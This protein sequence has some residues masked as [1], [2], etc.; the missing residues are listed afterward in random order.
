M[1]DSKNNLLNNFIGLDTP[2][3]LAD[4]SSQKRIH[5][6]GAA[7]PLVMKTAIEARDAL[8]PHYSNSHS[9]AHASAHI[10]GQAQQ[11][12][13]ETILS[14]CGADQRYSLVSLGHGTTAI[15]NNI[16]RRLNQRANEKPI[17]LVSAMEHHANDLP[18]RQQSASNVIHIPLKGES[19]TQGE[20]DLNA[21]EQL[22]IKHSGKVNYISF[23]GISNVTGIVNPI[24][25]ITQLAHNH[26]VLV[27]LDAAQ[28]A[29]HMDLKIAECDID[30]VA[31][32]GHKVYCAGS[33]GIMI[34]KSE[35]LAK[36][37]SDEVGGGVVDHVSYHEVDYVD[38]Y[39]Q[40]D[41]AGTKNVLG[42]YSLA[43]VMESMAEY[44]LD[45]IQEHGEQLWQYAES[46]L[47]DIDGLTIYGSTDMPRLGAL[48]FNI[49][50]LDHGFI[51]AVLS[52]YFGIA[53]R[54]QCFC[55]HP[56]V[57]SLIKEQLWDINLDDVAEDE[58]EALI[59]RKRGMVR[60]SF[61]LYNNKA[62]IEALV[63]ALKAIVSNTAEY[64]SHYDS[65]SDGAYRHKSYIV[66]TNLI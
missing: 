3:E 61:S 14:V 55:A 25:D 62:E 39:P 7:S 53:V 23:S 28:T 41:Q 43:K 59:D 6:D 18:H 47:S 57:S 60:A 65:L 17:V 36:Y 50:D 37:P 32:S 38:T 10:S 35:L 4:G 26:D 63:K 44:G 31:F 9:F 20:I 54:N 66:K 13:C 45:K 24:K 58:Q 40:R 19:I 34:A 5:L 48:S 1:T 30:F 49:I 51:A 2:Y 16:A 22:L 42:M 12:A 46:L 56:Y 11:W 27:I 21:L 15:I 52:D 8:L 33:P 29:P 64:L